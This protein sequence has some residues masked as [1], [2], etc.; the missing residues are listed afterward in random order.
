MRRASMVVGLVNVS[1]RQ[2]ITVHSLPI[3]WPSDASVGG[4]IMMPTWSTPAAG[5]LVRLACCWPPGYIRDCVHGAIPS[6]CA[7][8]ID[9]GL[10]NK[11]LV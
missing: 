10:V 4:S 2:M 3:T 9:R 11:A 5:A 7:T 1:V 6:Q 8:V